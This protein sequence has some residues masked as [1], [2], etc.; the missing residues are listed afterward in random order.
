MKTNSASTYIDHKV[1]HA[2]LGCAVGVAKSGDC[3]SGAFGGVIGE[4]VAEELANTSLANNLLSPDAKKQANAK[5]TISTI[6]QITSL[7]SASEAGLDFKT[8][9]QTANLEAVTTLIQA[10]A[11]VNVKDKY[12]KTPLHFAAQSSNNPKIV[13]ILIKA[14]ANVDARDQ[15]GKTSLFFVRDN[16]ITVILIQAGADV[17]THDKYGLTPLFEIA[18][19]DTNSNNSE[20]ML[21]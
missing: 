20:I 21:L 5:K 6:S 2:L 8:A 16:N 9:Q 17:N 10:G 1:L 18:F 13:T 4:I 7:F 3:A 15:N 12:G 19:S 11:D 14:G